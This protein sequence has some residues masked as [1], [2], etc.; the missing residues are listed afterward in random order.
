MYLKIVSCPIVS[1]YTVSCPHLNNT[2]IF[3]LISVLCFPKFG[4]LFIHL[5]PKAYLSN[6]NYLQLHHGV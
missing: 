1:V 4:N 5:N 2:V 3:L 6:H